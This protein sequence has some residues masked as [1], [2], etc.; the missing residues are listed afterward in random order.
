MPAGLLPDEGIG[1]QLTYLLSVPITGVTSWA[2]LLWTN[3]VQV[4]N[5]TVLADL[6]E[7]MW[8]GY[9]RATLDRALWNTPVVEQGCAMSTW[10]DVPLR[11]TMSG[12]DPVTNYGCAYLDILRSKLRF[13][14]RFEDADIRELKPGDEFKLLPRYTLTSAACGSMLA[15]KAKKPKPKRRRR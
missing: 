6:T 12:T 7:A 1:D 8:G 15:L 5:T 11:W 13:V 10:G 9:T 3:D 4:D 14:Q 2:L